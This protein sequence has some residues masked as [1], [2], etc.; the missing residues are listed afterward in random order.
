MGALFVWV[1]VVM[2]LGWLITATI[3]LF[4]YRRIKRLARYCAGSSAFVEARIM[5]LLS[6]RKQR[7]PI[8]WPSL[9]E[10][11]KLPWPKWS[12]V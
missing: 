12:K 6:W 8:G 1:S 2:F 7:N 10:W 5:S 9:S 4:L 3:L 11:R